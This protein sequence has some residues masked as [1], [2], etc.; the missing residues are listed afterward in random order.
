MDKW[1]EPKLLINA[2][3]GWPVHYSHSREYEQNQMRKVLE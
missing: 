1:K 3:I 2:D